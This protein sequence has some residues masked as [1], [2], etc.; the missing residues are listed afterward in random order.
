MIVLDEHLKFFN[1]YNLKQQIEKWYAGK[2]CYITE[3]RPQTVIKDDNISPILINQNQPTFVTINTIDFWKKIEA[4]KNYCII[5]FAIDDTR[6][7]EIPDTLRTIFIF[8]EFKTK[9]L[10]MGKIVR[11]SDQEIRFY[12]VEDKTVKRIGWK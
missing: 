7:R 11:V 3:L 10:R 12:T 2:V 1:L 4:H 8:D 6:V 5:C 9:A